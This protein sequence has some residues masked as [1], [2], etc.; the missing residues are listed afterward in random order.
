[1]SA[2]IRSSSILLTYK[3]HLDKEAYKKWL[4]SKRECDWIVIAHETGETGEYEHTHCYVKTSKRVDLASESTKVFDYLGIHPNIKCARDTREDTKKILRYLCKE[5]RQVE[6]DIKK[7][8]IELDID[9]APN[10]AE[11]VWRCSSIGEA[12]KKYCK[13]F[14]DAPGIRTI[15]EAKPVE[16]ELNIELRRWQ[17][18]LVEELERPANDRKIV[19]YID[20]NGGAGKTTL[21]KWLFANKR[22]L[23]IAGT[24]KMADVSTLVR[25]HIA[26][27]GKLEIVVVNL[28]RT[29]EEIKV[30]YKMI[31]QIKDGLMTAGKYNSKTVVFNS[32]HLCVS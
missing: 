10:I 7:L 23:I 20:E 27:Y 32:P 15:W 8:G 14:S 26:E 6:E 24:Q 4:S 12:M 28:T 19:W 13:K 17:N 22:A 16:Y 18:A 5:D 9:E 3:T 2:R 25:G 30:I 29:E 1:M 31:E 11:A 21:A